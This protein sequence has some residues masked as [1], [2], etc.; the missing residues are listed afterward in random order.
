[1][2]ATDKI[3]LSG[4]A[5]CRAVIVHYLNNSVGDSSGDPLETKI[6]K[7]GNDGS[8]DNQFTNDNSILSFTFEKQIQQPYGQF[9][10]ELANSKDWN[11]IISPGDWIGIYNKNG[12]SSDNRESLRLLGSVSKV[13][14]RM[15]ISNSGVR[16]TV[17][18]VSGM[19]CG[20]YFA[21]GQ[22]MVNPQALADKAY[23][24][25]IANQIQLL[26]GSSSQLVKSWTEFLLKNMAASIAQFTT[27]ALQAILVVPNNFMSYFFNQSDNEDVKYFYDI[28]QLKINDNSS[29]ELTNNLNLDTL[30]PFWT[31][32]KT[33]SNAVVNELFLEMDGAPGTEKPTLFH[34][35]YPF[36]KQNYN[37]GD[38]YNNKFIDL[39]S[40]E[41]YSNEISE[42]NFNI[43]DLERKNT[44]FIWSQFASEGLGA[45]VDE[46]IIT[47]DDSV[48]KFGSAFFRD[49]TRFVDY[50]DGG[51][52]GLSTLLMWQQ[53]CKHWYE[54]NHMFESG[55]IT[56]NGN[57]NTRVGKR[58]DIYGQYEKNDVKKS[59]YIEGYIDRWQFPGH[60]T[61]TIIATRGVVVDD[62]GEW[63]V[64]VYASEI[65]K[66]NAS[67]IINSG[68]R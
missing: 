13:S 19:D 43:S 28:L 8:S 29:Y 64:P 3:I 45:S 1:M 5:S 63:Y 56:I 10:L 38:I 40:V 17:W 60:W 59:Y 6:Y 11:V 35:P 57:P 47:I 66:F 18:T 20:K 2:D 22:V 61:Q 39:E 46:P 68:V 16:E 49:S 67:N 54:N 36:S 21:T 52:Q 50:K 44:F 26:E 33:M 48:V 62:N 14:K 65:T 31:I 27:G 53:L 34:R 25:Q 55:V 41:V 7:I 30:I 23:S 12:V 58:L 24:F 15:F 32:L 42:Y 4:T 9:F 51:Q 37:D